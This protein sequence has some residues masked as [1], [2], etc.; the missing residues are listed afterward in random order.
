MIKLKIKSDNLKKIKK[1][2]NNL[3]LSNNISICQNTDTQFN[4]LN[5][6]EMILDFIESELEEGKPFNCVI[7]PLSRCELDCEWLI[8]YQKY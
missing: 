6:N 5:Y 4:D 8:P 7:C 2:I 3:K 1:I